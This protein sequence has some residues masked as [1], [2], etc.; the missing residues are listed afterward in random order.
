MGIE[1]ALESALAT[2]LKGVQDGAGSEEDFVSVVLPC[3]N[4]AASVGLCV[5]EATETMARA[6]ISG[7]ILV[8]DNGSTDASEEIARAAGARVIREKRPGY[9]NALLAGITAARGPIVVM[10]DADWSYDFRKLPDLIEPIRTGSADLVLG[11]RMGAATRN[12]MPLLHRYVGSPFLTFLVSRAARGLPITDSQSGYRAFRREAALKLGLQSGGMEF[13]SEM[14][15]RAGHAGLRLSNVSTG[16]RP[17]IGRSK[18]SAFGD[19]W[20]H[21]KLIFLLAPNLLL[22]APGIALFLIGLLLLLMSFVSPA[23][24][25]VGSIRWQPIFFSSIAIILGMQSTLVGMMLA[26]RSPLVTAGARSRFR[27]VGRAGFPAKCV[28]IGIAAF[29][30]G[31]ALDGYLFARWL[32]ASPSAS[33]ALV[34]ASAAQTLLIAGGS[35]VSFGFVSWCLNGWTNAASSNGD[36]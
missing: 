25:A 36:A 20:R 17:R 2:D 3:L 24:L 5:R 31:L 16:Y 19:G 8:V 11:T 14:F 13:A 23:G 26:H 1:I 33:R 27:F 29:L 18:L 32:S 4:E 6:G 10:A 35:L 7:E 9:G 34:L 30:L 28:A 22:V 21:L 12:S 15:I